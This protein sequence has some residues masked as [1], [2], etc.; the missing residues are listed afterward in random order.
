MNRINALKKSA[1]KEGKFASFIIFNNIN[2]TYFT[3]FPGATAL[4]IPEQ[5]ESVL[6]VSAVNYEQAKKETNGLTVELLKRS[7]NLM[8]KIAN[9]TAS[10]KPSK[11]AVD[12]VPIESWLALAKAFGGEEKL[13]PANNFISEMRKTKDQQEIQSIRKACKFT[14]E[15]MQVAFEIIKPG[16]KERQAAAEIEY[17]MRKKGSEGTGFDT[18]IASGVASAFPHGSCSDRTIREGDLVV[19]D[20]G[21]T[22]NFYRSDM[23]RTFTAGNPSEEQNKIYETVK[24]AHQKAFK[25]MKPNIPAKEVD[26]AARQT[27]EAA[28]YGESFVHNLGHGV[29]LEIHEAP[30]LSPDSKDTLA[31]GNVITDEPGIYLSG[32]GGVRIEDT[33]L[34]TAKGAEKLTVG[35]YALTRTP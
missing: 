19:V 10:K 1:F 6:Y 22:F 9:Q 17:A 25:A 14:S 12:T 30:T 32:Y 24:L 31:A 29:G 21:A 7:E 5:G 28:G 26:A 34:V 16:V 11:F 15:G 20:L 35:P 4:L 27:I 3:S 2:L 8:T 23:T 33:V 13:E 18:I